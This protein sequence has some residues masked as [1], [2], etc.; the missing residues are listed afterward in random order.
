MLP[1]LQVNILQI[2]VRKMDNEYIKERAADILD[3]TKRLVR[4]LSGEKQNRNIIQ[5]ACDTCSS[6]NLSPSDTILLDKSM[7]LAFVLKRR[8][9]GQFSHCYSCKSNEYSCIDPGAFLRMIWKAAWP[10]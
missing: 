1:L 10:L 8:R 5:E 4:V 9:V 3:I 6:Q 2:C 7:I